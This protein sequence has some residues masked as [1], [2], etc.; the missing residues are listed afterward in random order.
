MAGFAKFLG[1]KVKSLYF[2]LY[3]HAIKLNETVCNVC[4]IYSL[5]ISMLL[6]TA[7][8]AWHE[9]GDIIKVGSR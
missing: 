7:Y 4:Y 8:I 6:T 1:L 5:F 9:E 2:W 3:G